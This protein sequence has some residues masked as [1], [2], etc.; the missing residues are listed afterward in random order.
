MKTVDTVLNENMAFHNVA[1]YLLELALCQDCI[2]LS[3]S[4]DFRAEHL[5]RG[6]TELF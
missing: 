4:L 3:R 2:M 1:D 5:R 6:Y